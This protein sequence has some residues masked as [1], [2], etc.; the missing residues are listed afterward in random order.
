[1]KP[2]PRPHSQKLRALVGDTRPYRRRKEPPAAIV[3]IS[4]SL[5]PP[6]WLDDDALA[7]WRILEPLVRRM[8]LLAEVDS[9]V[10]AGACCAAVMMETAYADVRT[11]GQQVVGQKGN[12]VCNPSCASSGT[13]R[14]F[15]TAW[16]VTWAS[17][18][19]REPVSAHRTTAVATARGGMSWSG[20]SARG[21]PPPPC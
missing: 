5:I 17:A 2:G 3:P 11:R 21:L 10:L 12:M 4:T 6:P 9:L 20:C 16:A 15:S 1:V 18:P 14:C 19:G 7:Q 8:G 13:L